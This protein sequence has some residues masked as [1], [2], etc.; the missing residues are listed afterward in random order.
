VIWGWSWTGF[1]VGLVIGVLGMLI[2]LEAAA[3]ARVASIAVRLE[4]EAE[5]QLVAA[6]RGD[7]PP[8]EGFKVDAS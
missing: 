3:R 8:P 6:L 4:R 2:G 1:V 5:D 7:G